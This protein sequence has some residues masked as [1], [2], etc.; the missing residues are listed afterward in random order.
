MQVYTTREEAINELILPQ[1]KDLTRITGTNPEDYDV[2][3]V[4]AEVLYDYS[5]GIFAGPT[6]GFGLHPEL[7]SNTFCE[8]LISHRIYN[9]GEDPGES[10]E[11][12]ERLYSHY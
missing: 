1:I 10:Q 9:L 5:E 12:L 6:T 8:I 4:A 3:A 11:E 7:T 2:E